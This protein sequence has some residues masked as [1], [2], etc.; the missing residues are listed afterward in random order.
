LSVARGCCHKKAA[1][2]YALRAQ[3][4]EV[5]MPLSSSDHLHDDSDRGKGSLEPDEPKQPGNSSMKGQLSHRNPYP[6]SEG[7]D[8]DFPLPGQS[9]LHSFEG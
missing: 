6:L 3:I 7:A 4:L 9:P 2:I 8:T 5:F 1:V